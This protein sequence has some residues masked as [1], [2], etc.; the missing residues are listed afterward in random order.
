MDEQ[1]PSDAPSVRELKKEYREQKQSRIKKFRALRWGLA[2]MILVAAGLGLWWF[3]GNS[4]DQQPGDSGILG[5]TENEWIHGNSEA[6]VTLVEYADFQCP[7]CGAYYPWIKNLEQD[8]P[9]KLAV[10]F[11]HFP[12]SAIHFN[13]L[14]AARAA[15]SAGQQGKF[16]EMHDM[17]F[18]NQQEWST[19]SDIESI[20]K[21]YAE[22]LGANV[23]QFL[24]DYNGK[25]FDAKIKNDLKSGE[26]A[27][28]SG[29]PTFFLNGAKINNPRGYEEFR[30]LIEQAAIE[31]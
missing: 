24:I 11:R 9:D 13:A 25:S 3:Y 15:E 17:I 7:A 1:S 30:N 26:A 6:A 27:G 18:E 12:L 10:V 31:Q 22:Q 21:R 8:F 4:I 14:P 5:L 20:F 2:G 19:S 28:V 16:W 29:T 23:E